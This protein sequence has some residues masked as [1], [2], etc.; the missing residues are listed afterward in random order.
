VVLIALLVVAIA[1]ITIDFRDGGNSGASSAGGHVFGPVERLAG[2]VTGVF[3]G[4]SGNSSEIANLQRQNDQLRAQLAQAQTSGIPASL[5]APTGVKLVLQA[6]A[7]GWQIYTCGTGP[8]GKPQW[9]LKA[10]DAE[11][12]D[13]KGTVVGHH[14]A[15]PTWKYS[16]GSQVMGKAVGMWTRRMQV[17]SL[18][19]GHR[20]QPL[21][22]RIVRQGVQHPACAHRGRTGAA[23][24]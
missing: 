6:H 22:R 10:P 23:G 3:R 21:G 4:T 19:A 8:D 17:D 5:Q 11:L 2:D 24:E 18:A 1:L 15:G 12:H 20:H 16:D 13:A 7:T 9:T 14:F